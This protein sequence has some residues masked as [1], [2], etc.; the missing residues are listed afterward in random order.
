MRVL[1]RSPWL[2]GLALVLGFCS[3]SW[4]QAAAD[5]ATD[6]AGSIV[7][8]PKVIADGTRDTLIELTNTANTTQYVHCIYVNGGGTCELTP[9]E[10]CPGEQ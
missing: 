8:F 1:K 7:I 10:Q 2:S 6:Q 4:G 9:D 5:V 3:L